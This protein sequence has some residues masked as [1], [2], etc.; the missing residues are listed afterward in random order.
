MFSKFFNF[1]KSKVDT[2]FFKNRE[3]VKIWRILSGSIFLPLGQ[4]EILSVLKLY[5]KNESK[6]FPKKLGHKFVDLSQTLDNSEKYVLSTA[7]TEDELDQTIYGNFYNSDSDSE[8]DCESDS[9]SDT[10]TI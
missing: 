5:F 7:T 6:K 10:F 8:S 2:N 3:L 9:L 1:F 4:N